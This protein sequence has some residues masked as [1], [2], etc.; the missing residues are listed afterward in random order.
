M[1]RSPADAVAL[2]SVA[3]DLRVA[4]IVN[5]VAGVHAVLRDEAIDFG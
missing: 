2:C 3:V 5:Q 4:Q 1:S